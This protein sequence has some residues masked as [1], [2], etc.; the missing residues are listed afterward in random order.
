MAETAQVRVGTG[1]HS[2]HE[3]KER[4][5]LGSRNDQIIIWNISLDDANVA[6]RFAFGLGLLTPYLNYIY[7][8]WFFF[9]RLWL[10]N[11]F[12]SKKERT[13]L[14][15]TWNNKA[16]ATKAKYSSMH[17]QCHMT[18]SI[19]K[20]NCFGEG[21]SRIWVLQLLLNILNTMVFEK[22][23]IEFYIFEEYFLN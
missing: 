23:D 12:T 15:S 1:R 14:M 4:E 22:N 20:Y 19:R 7:S 13:C 3:S 16:T 9:I 18:W 21:S 5:G 17:Q 10:S 11:F 6:T 2:T 8:N